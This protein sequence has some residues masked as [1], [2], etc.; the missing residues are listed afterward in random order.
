MN[1]LC[2]YGIILLLSSLI[3]FSF[4]R[5]QEAMVRMDRVNASKTFRKQQFAHLLNL[6]SQSIHSITHG[7]ALAAA[8]G[9]FGAAGAGSDLIYGTAGL[10][11]QRP[12]LC[13]VVNPLPNP[14]HVSLIQSVWKR[15][16][17]KSAGR[18]VIFI[19]H[20]CPSRPS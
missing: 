6:L 13:E 1:Q 8:V 15:W 11:S 12:P 9:P 16:Q 18:W 17:R 4:K 7:S 3:Q 20:H 2:T 14:C 5:S 10:S 19:W